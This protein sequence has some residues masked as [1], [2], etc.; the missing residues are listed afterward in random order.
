MQCVI[1]SFG[2]IVECREPTIEWN[3]PAPDQL[4]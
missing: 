3:S 1:L 2:P 4:P